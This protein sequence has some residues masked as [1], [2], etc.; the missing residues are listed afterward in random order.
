MAKHVKEQSRLS[1]AKTRLV[2]NLVL[3]LKIMKHDLQPNF[4]LNIISTQSL[5]I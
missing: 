4:E 3:T 5:K 2:D 1:Y